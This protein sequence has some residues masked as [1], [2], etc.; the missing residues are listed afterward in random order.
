MPDTP[1]DRIAMPT[2][3]SEA[4]DNVA[5]EVNQGIAPPSRK[6]SLARQ[7][8]LLTTTLTALTAVAALILSLISTVQLNHRPQISLTIPSVLRIAQ[9]RLPQGD[10]R[11]EVNIQPT[12]A[13][14][15]KTDLTGVITSLRLNMIP[16]SPLNSPPPHFVWEDIIEYDYD[17]TTGGTKGKIISDPGPI[18]VTQDKPQSPMLRFIANQALLQSGRW[19]ATLTAERA[20]QPPLVSEFCV[21]V[22]DHMM[23][24]VAPQGTPNTLGAFILRND[25]SSPSAQTPNCYHP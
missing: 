10:T 22:S 14:Y 25:Q 3:R 11:V 5:V 2:P 4:S 15:E 16:P 23:S 19:R 21:D 20:G 18:I 24:A 8:E 12:F 1:D 13:V 9:A 17:I 7:V 6:R